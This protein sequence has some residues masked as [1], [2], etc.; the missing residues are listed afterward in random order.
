MDESLNNRNEDKKAI[1]D[2]GKT[3]K[4]IILFYQKTTNNVVM[5]GDVK[6]MAS[7]PAQ[8]EKGLKIKISEPKPYVAQTRTILQLIIKWINQIW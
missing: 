8:D 5:K 3:W 4:Q 1:E 7:Q 6:S 2:L